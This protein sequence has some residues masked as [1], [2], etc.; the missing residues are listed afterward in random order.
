MKRFCSALMLVVCTAA[1]W[2][3]QLH[4]GTIKGM[5]MYNT[6]VTKVIKEAGFETNITVYDQQPQLMEAFAKGEVDGAFFLAQ[7]LIQQ[8]KGAFMISARLANSDFCAVTIDPDIKIAN[9]GDLRKYS[10]GIVKGHP[11]HTAV[12]RGMKVIEAANEVEQFKM[13]AEGKF[14]AAVSVIDLIVPMT[15]AAGITT[16]A[17]QMPPLL[18]TPT[19]IALSASQTAKKDALEAA[20]KKWIDNGKWEAET[21]KL[22]Q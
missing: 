5:H 1:L 8:V 11:G 2:C 15:K 21:A 6:L 3:Q 18:R 7:P 10:V 19:F 22:K 12:T 4:F 17:T 13:L 20:F 9:P 16:Y 14:Q